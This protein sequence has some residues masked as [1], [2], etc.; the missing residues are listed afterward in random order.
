MAPATG[1]HTAQ[2]RASSEATI[3]ADPLGSK[4]PTQQPAD[5]PWAETRH[6]SPAAATTTKGGSRD[7]GTSSMV[8]GG[9]PRF[10]TDPKNAAIE[11]GGEAVDTE[12]LGGGRM[13]Q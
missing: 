10:R 1:V 5:E 8:W 13:R 4:I 6:P 9:V 3:A 2:N 11:L 12:E 7:L